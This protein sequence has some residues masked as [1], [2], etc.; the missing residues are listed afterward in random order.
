[1]AIK[2]KQRIKILSVDDE[3]DIREVVGDILEDEGYKIF[4]ASNAEEAKNQ[5]VEIS[6]DLILL[7]IWM[8][9]VDGITLLS[10]WQQEYGKNIAPIIMMSGHGNIEMA[11]EATKLGAFYFLEKPLATA[12]L[13]LTVERALELK[14]MQ[15]K[16]LLLQEKINPK[17]DLIGN[18]E[19]VEKLR[20]M[21]QKLSKQSSPFLIMGKNGTGREHF[22][23][24]VHS[25][26]ENSDEP[27]QVLNLSYTDKNQ[28]ENIRNTIE[29]NPYGCIYFFD[30]AKLS[31]K[32]QEFFLEVLNK[33]KFMHNGQEID[34]SGLRIITGTISNDDSGKSIMRTNLRQEIFDYLTIAT[35][36]IPTLKE[37]IADLPQLLEYFCR[38]FSDYEQ[39]PYRHFDMPAQNALRNHNWQGNVQELKNLVQR[40]LIQNDAAEIGMQEALE[41]VVPVETSEEE[42]SAILLQ[43]VSKN[44][45]LR[46]AREE[47]E[48]QYLNA[49]Y[50][51]CAGSIAK[52]AERVGMDRTNLYRKLKNLN[53][54]YRDKPEH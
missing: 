40:L 46:D 12:K 43:L 18:S 39:L 25:L 27:F 6:P 29:K 14:K 24:Y 38:Y 52:L 30:I 42:Q 20:Q 17:V 44:L 8:P 7:D 22:A 1:M 3:A 5:Y 23:R 53:I 4:T 45:S 26:S 21:A 41:A 16:N 34:C 31:Q 19:Q 32:S 47:F 49:Q 36:E 9:D 33:R 15:K 11:V 10:A 48:R 37:R 2:N 13:L 28:V 50:R 51:L 35:V 54:D